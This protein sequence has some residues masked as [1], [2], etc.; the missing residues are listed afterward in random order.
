MKTK[1]LSKKA[2]KEYEINYLLNIL[3]KYLRLKYSPE[4]CHRQIE[5]SKY[6]LGIK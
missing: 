6:N 4:E 2:I 1:L 3:F 5:I